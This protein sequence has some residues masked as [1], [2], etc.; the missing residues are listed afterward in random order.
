M[1]TSRGFASL[2][3]V[4]LILVVA[5]GSRD[6]SGNLFFNVDTTKTIADFGTAEGWSGS[7]EQAV[8]AL[9]TVA[10]TGSVT[11]HSDLILS[12]GSNIQVSHF[13]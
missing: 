12:G 8:R 2:G 9:G 10:S 4:L 3:L 7:T 1:K 5:V 13:T 6:S 11:S